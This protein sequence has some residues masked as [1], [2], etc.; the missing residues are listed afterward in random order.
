M[1]IRAQKVWRVGGAC[2]STAGGA[3]GKRAGRGLGTE[4]FARPSW[5]GPGFLIIYKQ[6]HANPELSAQE[7]QTSAEVAKELRAAVF[8]VTDHFG[9]YASPETKGYGSCSRAA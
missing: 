8:D 4:R 2:W 9:Q 3:G 7:E 1:R 5:Q 6:L